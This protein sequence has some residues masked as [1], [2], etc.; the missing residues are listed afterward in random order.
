MAVRLSDDSGVDDAVDELL[1]SASDEARRTL[2]I[3]CR[4]C[5][6]VC[7]CCRLW[8]LGH[9]APPASIF[10]LIVTEFPVYLDKQAFAVFWSAFSSSSRPPVLPFVLHRRA[11]Q[12]LSIDVYEYVHASSTEEPERQKKEREELA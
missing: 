8:V 6:C 10:P 2:F 3:G 4:A 1:G 11:W 7:L 9:Q 12:S 5:C